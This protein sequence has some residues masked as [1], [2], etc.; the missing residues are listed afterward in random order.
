MWQLLEVVF[1]V[2]VGVWIGRARSF[3]EMAL[4]GAGLVAMMV[5]AAALTQEDW[6]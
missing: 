6:D 1:L 4:I 5:I 2:L 3:W